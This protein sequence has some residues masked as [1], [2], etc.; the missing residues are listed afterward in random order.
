[1]MRQLDGILAGL[2]A[3]LLMICI[4]LWAAPCSAAMIIGTPVVL[5]TLVV[6]GA[7]IVVGDKT[8]AGFTYSI[9]G[10]MPPATLVN[11]IPITDDAGNF[12]IR[13]QGAFIDTTG[14]VGGSD[15]LI[16]YTV[17]T[18]ASHLISDAH[19]EGNPTRLG[20]L[21]SMSV[22]ETFLPLGAN[23]QFTMKIY[24]DQNVT[25][26]KLIDNTI[27]TTPVKTLNVQKD[28]LGLAKVD[29]SSPNAPQTVTM[30]FVDQTFSQIVIPEPTTVAL[31][32]AG[33]FGFASIRRRN[34]SYLT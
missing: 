5:S 28:I 1:M 24:D 25:P 27:F 22:T 16:T 31:L 30:S 10:D 11:V 14:A 20:T 21:G 19:L 26:P 2:G 23:G 15:A 32:F 4:S 13:F 18:D 8:F 12:G 34:A 6:P 7:T 3:L 9:T 33:T 17:T 29:Q